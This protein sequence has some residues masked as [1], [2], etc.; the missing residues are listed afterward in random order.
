MSVEKP[1]PLRLGRQARIKHRRDFGQLRQDGKRLANGCLLANWRVLQGPGPSRLGVIT[2]SKIGN[3]V[4][5]SRARRQLRQAFRFHQHDLAQTVDIVLVARASICGK[6]FA[7]VQADYV[8]MLRKA[9]L[10]KRETGAGGVN[11]VN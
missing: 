8:V 4:M 3:A 7:Q 11:Q 6:S 10:L 9:G 5:R 1:Q 2:S